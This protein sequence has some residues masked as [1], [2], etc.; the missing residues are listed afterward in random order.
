MMHK[1]RRIPTLVSRRDPLRAVNLGSRRMAGRRAKHR[2]SLHKQRLV[3]GVL[4]GL[5]KGRKARQ[6]WRA[7]GRTLRRLRRRQ[8]IQ[9]SLMLLTQN[10]QGKM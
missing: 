6:S 1:I 4:G 10:S 8:E 5:L 9:G 7:R 2:G 3:R